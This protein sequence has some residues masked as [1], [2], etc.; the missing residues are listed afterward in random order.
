MALA[1][2]L[3]GFASATQD[4]V[5]DAYRI[6]AA[7]TR[8]QVMM[9]STYIAGYRLG[10]I[11]LERCIVFGFRDGLEKGHYVDSAWA[12]DCIMAVTMLV[13]VLTTLLIPEPERKQVDK[14]HYAAVDYMRLVRR[15]PVR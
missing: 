10:M 9:S 14:H 1:A 15:L 6:E 13:G 8:L 5:I 4:I 3:L 2:V 11:V 7:E 12:G